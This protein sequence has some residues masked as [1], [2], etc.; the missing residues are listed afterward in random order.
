MAD[1]SSFIDQVETVY[2]DI[3]NVSCHRLVPYYLMS[4]YLYYKKDKSV[5][6]DSD[7][8]NMC[9]RIIDMWKEIK[10]PH[11]SLVKK[12]A[13]EAGTG[14]QIRKYPTITMSAAELWNTNWE[15]ENGK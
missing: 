7:Y 15:K 6:S 9:R 3:N 4:S 14:Y 2:P 12:K 1:L 13:L 10:H 5:L 8:D 11:K